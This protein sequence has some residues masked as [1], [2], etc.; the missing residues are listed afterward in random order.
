M[1]WLKAGMLILI[2]GALFGLF[3]WLKYIPNSTLAASSSKQIDEY[4]L[5]AKITRY[6]K[7]G[8]KTQILTMDKAY[9]EQG[10]DHMLILEPKLSLF[11]DSNERSCLQSDWGKSVHGE[12]GQLNHI[13]LHDHVTITMKQQP[14]DKWILETNYLL[15]KPYDKLASTHKPVSL[16]SHS[17]RIAGEGMDADLN[18]GIITLRQK[19]KGRYASS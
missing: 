5:G 6:N 2:L 12:R 14:D 3:Q 15:I 9:H 8:Q 4:M 11:Q 13:E 1:K 16:F 10:A 19:V 18:T 7:L 17:Y